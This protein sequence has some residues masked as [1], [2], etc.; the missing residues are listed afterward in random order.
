MT[1]EPSNRRDLQR[2]I[3][4]HGANNANRNGICLRIR[5][6]RH[7]RTGCERQAHQRSQEGQFFAAVQARNTSPAASISLACK[8]IDMQ[9]A[10]PN[11]QGAMENSRREI[12][13]AGHHGTSELQRQFS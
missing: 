1:I 6:R 2:N 10:P 13:M 5:L 3:L 9:Q 4:G 7:A 11:L 12:A 8:T